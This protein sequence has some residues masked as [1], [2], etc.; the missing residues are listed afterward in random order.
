[1]PKR[2][3]GRPCAGGSR[4]ADDGKLK[5]KGDENDLQNLPGL[6]EKKTLELRGVPVPGQQPVMDMLLLR[7]R[8]RLNPRQAAGAFHISFLPCGMAFF[9]LDRKVIIV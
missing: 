6:P 2:P 1:M 7:E 9:S 5:T 4:H 3:R 8:G